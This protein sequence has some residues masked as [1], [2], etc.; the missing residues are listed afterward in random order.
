MVFRFPLSQGKGSHCIHSASKRAVH[1]LLLITKV[2]SKRY[3]TG[4]DNIQLDKTATATN[5]KV[6]AALHS[7]FLKAY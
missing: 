3:T 7:V 1:L 5:K 6:F 2:V 4:L